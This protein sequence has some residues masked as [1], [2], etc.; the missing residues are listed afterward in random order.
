M[1]SYVTDFRDLLDKHGHIP[2]GNAQLRRMALRAARLVEYGG[3]L[4]VGESRETLAECVR[5]PG[6]VPCPM[7]LWVMK[8]ADDRIY[9]WCP[10]CHGDEFYISGWQDTDWADGPMEPVPPEY[11]PTPPT[12]TDLDD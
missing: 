12:A 9:G 3:P 7:M 10:A 2:T 6:G 11:G 1:P 4:K 8:L 5:R